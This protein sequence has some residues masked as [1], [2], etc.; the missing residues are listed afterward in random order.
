[1]QTTRHQRNKKLDL[2]V[3]TDGMHYVIRTQVPDD[4]ANL[5]GTEQTSEWKN[6]E[7]SEDIDANRQTKHKREKVL[8]KTMNINEAHELW[9][10]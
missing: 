3:G 2:P 9:G 1:M 5:L 7:N 6:A 4:A 8:P 10:H